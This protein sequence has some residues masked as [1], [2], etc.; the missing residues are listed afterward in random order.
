MLPAVRPLPRLETFPA[1][2]RMAESPA[3][4]ILL[5][6]LFCVLARLLGLSAIPLYLSLVA[7]SLWPERRRV[8]VAAATL[9]MLAGQ[10]PG[11]WAALLIVF[12]AAWLVLALFQR[13]PDHRLFR[14]P[15]RNL[16]GL[17]CILLASVSYMPAPPLIKAFMW[18]VLAFSGKYLWFMCYALSDRK[19]VARQS[20]LLTLCRF[21]PFWGGSNVPFP[22]GE[23]NLDRIEANSSGD[24]ALCQLR[25]M[26]LMVW[27][28]LLFAALGLLG[29]IVQQP[30]LYDWWLRRIHFPVRITHLDLAI[31]LYLKGRPLPRLD[32]W[33][34]VIASF[35]YKM[36]NVSA[37]GGAI[38]A[39][40]RMAGF[41][42]VRNTRKP[43]SA[44]TI[45]E[46]YNRL[47]YYFKELLVTF[48]FYPTYFRYFKNRPRLRV[49]VAT[50]AAA[51]FGN[52]LFHFLRDI[53]FTI[54]YGLWR[55]LVGFQVYIV[56][57][58]ILGLSIAASQLRSLNGNA[59]GGR[60][61]GPICVLTFYC[62]V[63][64][65]DDP[66]RAWN[67]QDYFSFIINLFVPFQR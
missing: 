26:E 14:N 21:Q 20:P 34:S 13:R 24:L 7:L 53:D 48:F 12:P 17:Y 5:V 11:A 1:I 44:R 52:A 62:L 60:F 22:K 23:A 19:G 40:C 46:F 37:W 43:L 49:F 58:L 59:Q 35:C 2:V 36:L 61:T 10:F 39:T 30:G 45:A 9:L 29:R 38:I 25:G 4:R 33:L 41:N 15:T 3:G 6:T 42:A 67:V 66:N 47:Y 8:I 50:L 54:K 16:L 28:S 27:S 51:G 65:L 18:A 55:S 63:M 57:T 32:C 56:Y 64:I 31:D